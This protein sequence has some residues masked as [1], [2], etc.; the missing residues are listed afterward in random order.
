MDAHCE[1]A[2]L[3][4][5]RT[6]TN[7]I[8]DIILTDLVDFLSI[9][10]YPVTKPSLLLYL[11]VKYKIH[12][13]HI[14]NIIQSPAEYQ[15]VKNPS[16]LGMEGYGRA[17]N[18]WKLQKIIR[19]IRASQQNSAWSFKTDPQTEG[20]EIQK[21]VISRR[22]PTNQ[23]RQHKC[24]LPGTENDQTESSDKT[25]ESSFRWA[26][27]NRQRRKITTGSDR[28]SRCRHRQ[29]AD[30]RKCNAQT[31]ENGNKKQGLRRLRQDRP[32]HQDLLG[33]SSGGG[34]LLGHQ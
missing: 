29:R 12:L 24:K 28:Y 19:R 23:I 15:L 13:C 26:K 11:S 25:K 34:R 16:I 33:I 18:G 7:R 10:A 6:R 27:N 2:Q 21:I 17:H 8:R 14:V 20:E 22:H 5:A 31:D 32:L 1:K 4:Y 3:I 9:L 30:I